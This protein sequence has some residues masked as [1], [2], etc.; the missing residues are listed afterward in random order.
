MGG[1][2]V[3][4]KLGISKQERKRQEVIFEVLCTERDYVEDLETVIEVYIKQ[5]KKNKLLRPK[6]MSVIFSNIETIMP[7]NSEL[8]KLLEDRQAESENGV[9]EQ[10][11]DI[12]IRVSDYL[13]IYTILKPVQRICKYPLLL[14]EMIKQTDA[15]HPD[16]ANLIKALMKIETVVTIVNEGARQAEGVHKMIELQARFTQKVNIVA[17]SRTMKKFGAMDLIA[18]SG[19]RKKRELFLFNDMLLMA[20]APDAHSDRLKVVAIVPFDMILINAPQDEPGKENLIEIVHINSA[21]F[22]LAGDSPFTKTS[23]IKAFTEVTDAWMALKGSKL[24]SV[25]G[26]VIRSDKMSE[27]DKEDDIESECGNTESNLGV[28]SSLS[29]PN[30]SAR[31]SVNKPIEEGRAQSVEALQDSGADVSTFKEVSISL[32][33]L[34]TPSIVETRAPPPLPIHGTPLTAQKPTTAQSAPAISVALATANTVVASSSYQRPAAAPAT[35]APT[36]PISPSPSTNF[37]TLSSAP[38]PLSSLKPPS[39]TSN[40]SIHD[41]SEDLSGSASS[42]SG[43]VSPS[44]LRSHSVRAPNPTPAGSLANL[45]GSNSNLSGSNHNLSAR[46]ASNHFIVQDLN[47]SLMRASTP[48]PTHARSATAD[49]APPAAPYQAAIASQ[50][51]SEAVHGRSLSAQPRALPPRGAGFSTSTSTQIPARAAMAAAQLPN[52]AFQ[53]NATVVDAALR[54]RGLVISA[55]VKE[56]QERLAQEMAAFAVPGTAV[57][58]SG[59]V[60]VAVAQPP[61]TPAVVTA[62]V[63][64]RGRTQSMVSREAEV[65]PT[66]AVNAALMARGLMANTGALGGQPSLKPSVNAVKNS[67]LQNTSVDE[68]SKGGDDGDIKQKKMAVNKPIKHAQVV[69]VARKSKKDLKDFVYTLRVQYIGATDPKGF[70]LI[71]HTYEDFFDLHLNLLGHFPE[72][73]GTQ[74]RNDGEGTTITTTTNRIIPEL[75]GQ[76]MFVSEAVAKSRMATLQGYVQQCHVLLGVRPGATRNEIRAAFRRLALRHHPDRNGPDANGDRFREISEAYQVLM[77]R[78]EERTSVAG[79]PP[80]AEGAV[81]VYAG[82]AAAKDR[83]SQDATRPTRKA[84]SSSCS[85][86]GVRADTSPAATA[87]SSACRGSEPHKDHIDPFDAIKRTHSAPNLQ[88]LRGSYVHSQRYGTSRAGS[89]VWTAEQGSGQQQETRPHRES[90]GVAGTTR[91]PPAPWPQPVDRNRPA[92]PAGRQT[93]PVS[94]Q[95]DWPSKEREAS[96]EPASG[97]ARTVDLDDSRGSRDLR[98]TP[99]SLREKAAA[100]AA[101]LRVALDSHRSW[102]ARDAT[103]TAPGVPDSTVAPES[104]TEDNSRRKMNIF[105][106]LKERLARMKKPKEAEAAAAGDREKGEGDTEFGATMPAHGKQ[107]EPDIEELHKM[108]LEVDQEVFWSTLHHELNEDL[109]LEILL[110]LKARAQVV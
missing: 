32:T 25:E 104:P 108:L 16:S 2:E 110:K 55:T 93:P 40:G 98:P 72:E 77:E 52:P 27:D 35:R 47:A 63:S 83:R 64:G 13:K 21:K 106:K 36:R 20:K 3:V 81:P 37:S 89:F 51:P 29:V 56:R 34:A 65:E 70:S 61:P 7:V 50:P 39:T 92:S 45:N 58:D 73:A 46:I 96:Q 22:T 87:F 57:A 41:S 10:V 75:P 53:R 28:L 31:P 48:V 5:L 103:P 19:E 91:A 88:S 62:P 97:R 38:R 79:D 78:A 95:D 8:L 84:S 80:L 85:Q 74:I 11:G 90:A 4:D 24:D 54:G 105:T 18:A 49:P 107:E 76:M 109:M 1:A 100:A 14:R 15:S 86:G 26:R 42:L 101:R 59:K 23:W 44:V 43:K 94:S 9:V 33:S 102:G 69:D 30:L 68:D 60:S 99:R 82:G 12:F 17:P 71:H 6:D 67:S 66:T